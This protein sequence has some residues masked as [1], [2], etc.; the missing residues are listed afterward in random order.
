MNLNLAE[1]RALLCGSTDGIGKACAVLM[2][3]RGAQ[4]IL[5]ARN[6]EKIKSVISNLKGE[7]HSYICANFDEPEDLK[8]KTVAHLNET[9]PVHIL[10]NNTGG[11]HGGPLLE[12][13]AAE[14][15]IAFRRHVIANQYLAQAVVPGMK[16]LGYGR[17]I[18]IISTSVRQ[19]IPGLGVS[20]T[21]RGAVAQWAKTLAL[22][23][24]HEG[25]TINNILPGYTHTDRLKDLLEKWAEMNGISYEEMM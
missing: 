16:E 22:E 2:A 14:F 15:E 4:I 25:I 24:G 11:P 21:I 12:A 1:K 7:G 5:A 13:K 18:N 6:E 17:I 3:E 9:G 10:M 20:N 19:V 8:K 23:L